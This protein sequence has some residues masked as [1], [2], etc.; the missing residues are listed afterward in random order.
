[1]SSPELLY[2]VAVNWYIP[3]QRA[4]S[5]RSVC[6]PVPVPARLPVRNMILPYILVSEE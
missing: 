6:A 1:M 5:H 2:S 3:Y 4:R